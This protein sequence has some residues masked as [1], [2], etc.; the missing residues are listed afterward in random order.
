LTSDFIKDVDHR[1]PLGKGD[2]EIVT[3]N[4]NACS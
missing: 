2:Y 3:F 4:C 1:V